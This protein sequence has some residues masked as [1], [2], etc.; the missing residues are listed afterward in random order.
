[1]EQP[2]RQ[3]DWEEVRERLTLGAW[4]L[5]V[6]RRV[7]G[8]GPLVPGFGSGPED[9]AHGL[10][11]ALLDPEDHTVHWNQ[12]TRGIATTQGVTAYL[13]TAM[14]ND[15]LDLR[16]AKRRGAQVPLQTAKPDGTVVVTHEPPDPEPDAETQIMEQESQVPFLKRLEEDFEAHPDDEL[17]MY[18]LLQ[19]ED[20]K[21]APYK[22]REAADELGVSVE[23]IYLL[24]EKLERRVLRLFRDELREP[25]RRSHQENSYEQEAG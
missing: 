9:L 15:F 25:V 19:F 10:L 7:V 14:K 16:R 11:C 3:V 12:A 21:Y 24:K 5:F 18:V 20:G 4:R 22:P 1:M 6:A 23:R 13:M 17:Q 2:F 8:G